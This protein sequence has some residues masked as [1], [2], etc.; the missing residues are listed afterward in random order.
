MKIPHSALPAIRT[1]ILLA[2]TAASAFVFLFFW[3]SVGG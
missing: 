1:T 3:T 2:F